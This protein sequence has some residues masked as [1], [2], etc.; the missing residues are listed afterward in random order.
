MRELGCA[1][2]IRERTY[3]CEN[4]DP[5]FRSFTN[6]ENIIKTICGNKAA[7]TK[8]RGKAKGLQAKFDDA[9]T[10]CAQ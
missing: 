10:G 9:S 5:V 4:C 3:C 2:C 7:G 1:K 8:A 6:D